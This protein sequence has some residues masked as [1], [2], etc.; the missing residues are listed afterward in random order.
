MLDAFWSKGSR[1]SSER[2]TTD[3]HAPGLVVCANS[4]RDLCCGLD[5]RALVQLLDDD[6]VWECSH[7][8]GHR[9]APTALLVGE[10][11]VYGR[12]DAAAARAL[13]DDGPTSQTAA[14]LRGRSGLAP[15]A[16]AAEAWL[17]GQ[18]ARPDARTAACENVDDRVQV[19][20]TGVSPVWL[21][22][23][24][25]TPRPA[26]CGAEPE[27]WSAWRVLDPG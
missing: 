7:L 27:S 20:F 5:G 17:L 15:A 1:R 23:E 6:R 21:A 26:S 4:A 8:G 11:L 24:S 19:T 25:G 12:L 14:Y 22:Q 3:A 16:Q 2:A 9:F 13:L 10:G 18:G